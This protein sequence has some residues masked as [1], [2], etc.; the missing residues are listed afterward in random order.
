MP[1]PTVPPIR[2]KG[3]G[4]SSRPEGRFETTRR[5][6]E[7]DGWYRD[8]EPASPPATV[9]TEERARHVITR[10]QS[11]DVPF[12]AS[13]NAYRGCEHGCAYCYARP[14]HAY[15]NLSPGLDFETR[16]FAK[17]NAA[18]VL[19]VELA[20]KNYRCTPINLGANT[21]PYQ[22]IERRYRITRAV[23]EVLLAHRHPCTI[24]TKNALVERDIDLL[25]P[26]AAQRLVHV[27]ISVTSLDNR[28]SSRLEPRASAP[29]RRLGAIATLN[30]AGVPCSVLVAPIIPALTD[31]DIEGILERA[32]QA[33]APTA[34]YTLLRLP[35]ELKQLFEEWLATHQPDRAAH[36]LGILRQIRGGELNEPRF[37]FR[38]RG[39]GTFA[40]L[41]RQRFYLA[42]RRYG[43][44]ARAVGDLDTTAFSPPRPPSAQGELF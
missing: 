21:D 12:T 19:R 10:N 35:Y 40:E 13:L 34:G 44:G 15:L 31:H 29:H 43:I 5:E 30:A 37:G 16:L 23:L 28:L 42:C 27:F 1:D 3:R 11:P 26:M 4:S 33:G 32:A 25:A 6:A 2:I 36:V 17:T 38:M 14:S 8:G 7:D 9:V 22:P 24:I 20:R 41:I 39:E 18:D